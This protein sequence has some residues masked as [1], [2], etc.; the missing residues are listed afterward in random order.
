MQVWT[1][2]NSALCVEVY[3]N[4]SHIVIRITV[5]AIIERRRDFWSAYFGVSN[6]THNGLEK[7]EMQ[8][9]IARTARVDKDL[10]AFDVVSPG[11]T[12]GFGH[13]CV[14]LCSFFCFVTFDHHVQGLSAAGMDRRDRLSPGLTKVTDE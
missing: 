3:V 14:H 5:H 2:E 7:F 6:K 13:T 10:I 8:A 1:G 9:A 11:T 4:F 12:C